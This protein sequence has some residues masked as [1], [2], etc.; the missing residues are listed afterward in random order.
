MKFLRICA[1][2]TAVACLICGCATRPI[3]VGQVRP[4][5]SPEAVR[6]YRA[7]PRHFERIAIINSSAGSTWIFWPLIKSIPNFLA[8]LFRLWRASF[9]ECPHRLN[10]FVGRS[11]GIGPIV[12]YSTQLGKS[13]LDFNVRWIHD[14]DVSKAVQGDGFNFT[15]SLKF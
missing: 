10:G 6:V 2:T 1:A 3:I 13:N 15:A 8:P 11:F 14:F 12:T 9:I 5:I 4:P 7:P